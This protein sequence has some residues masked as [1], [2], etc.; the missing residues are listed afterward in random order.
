MTVRDARGCESTCDLL[1][2]EPQE[3][4]CEILQQVN[5]ACD[6]NDGIIEVTALGGVGVLSYQLNDGPIQTSGLF[7][8]LISGTYDVSIHDENNCI[9]QCTTIVLDN[10]NGL[11]SSI[12]IVDGTM[13]GTGGGPSIVTNVTGGEQPY[14]YSLDSGPYGPSG[15][16]TDLSIGTHT[17]AVRDASGCINMSTVEITDPN[18]LSCTVTSTTDTSCDDPLG[19]EA[20]IVAGGGS[21]ILTYT[22][23]NGQSNNTGVFTGLVGGQYSVIVEDINGC[24]TDCVFEITLDADDTPEAI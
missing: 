22:L 4:T 10:P 11:S 20:T 15:E 21:G 3:I 9:K 13:C 1:L 23:S 18:Q 5:P 19:G 17:V 2:L 6:A 8:D 7:E 14:E 12:D 16:F 24:T